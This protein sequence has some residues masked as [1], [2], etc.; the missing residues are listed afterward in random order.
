M[1]TGNFH[2]KGY[3]MLH[4]LAGATIQVANLVNYNCHPLEDGNKDFTLWVKIYK[5]IF[6][7]PYPLLYI[8]LG[9]HM[10]C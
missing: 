8:M 7:D 3:I 5:P 4:H 10:L 2:R 9:F 6:T 1:H